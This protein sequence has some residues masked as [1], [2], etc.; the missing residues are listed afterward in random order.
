MEPPGAFLKD[1]QTQCLI[2]WTLIKDGGANKNI[3]IV[4]G[5]DRAEMIDAIAITREKAAA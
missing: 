5:P 2:L 3:R 4:P 1:F